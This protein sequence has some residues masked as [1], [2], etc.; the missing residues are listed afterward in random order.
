MWLRNDT[1]CPERLLADDEFV[2]EGNGDNCDGDFYFSGH[3][4]R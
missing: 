3:Q 4:L 1:C 2:D